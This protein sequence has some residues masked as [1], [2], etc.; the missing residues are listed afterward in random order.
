MPNLALSPLAPI[1]GQRVP[2]RGPARL[3]IRSYSRIQRHPGTSVTRLTTKSGDLFDADMANGLEWQLWAFGAFE[4]HF[5]E[6]FGKLVRPATI[7]ASTTC[8]GPGSSTP[9][10][11]TAA[12]RHSCT[13]RA[14]PTR[15]GAGPACCNTPT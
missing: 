11:A 10:P 6:L 13:G 4:G 2:L 5:A 12:G 14:Q 1:L 8:P 3:L 15:T 9:P 7:S